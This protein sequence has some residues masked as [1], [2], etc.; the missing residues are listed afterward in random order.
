MNTAQTIASIGFDIT[1]LTTA[2]AAPVTFNVDLM[3]DKDGE[4]IAGL[5]VVG[6][7]SPEYQAENH[8][9]R[10]EGYQRSARRKTAIDA[11][12]DD[13][14]EQLVSLI[15]ANQKRLALAVVVGWYGFSKEGQPAPFD[16]GVVSAAFDKYPTWLDRTSAALEVDA[17][18]LKV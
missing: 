13:G 14:A 8:A 17:N 10:T 3:F 18:F 15:D 11:S 6:K 4:P 12:T 1:N 7:N 5:I 16:K 2:A 9:I